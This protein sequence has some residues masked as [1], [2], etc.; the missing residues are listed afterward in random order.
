MDHEQVNP[1]ERDHSLRVVLPG[2]VEK[3]ATVHGS[4]AVMDLLVTLCASYHLNPSDYTVEVLSANRDNVSFKPN[5]PI[6][7]LEA[8]KIVLRSRGAVEEKIRRPYMPEATVRLLINYNKSHKTVVR[9]NPRLPLATLLPAVCDKCEFNVGTTVLLRD[10]RSGETL[11]LSRTLNE[12]GLREVF[13]RDTAGKEPADH[14][15]GAA[16]AEVASPPPLQELPKKEQKEQKEQKEN[17]GFLSLFRR[18]KKK[19][20][21]EGEVSVPPAPG[22]GERA[23]VGLESDGVSSS[24]ALPADGPKKRRAP[25]PPPGASLSLTN[26]LSSCSLGGAQTSAESTL[27]STK[28][29]APPPPPCANPLQELQ[30]DAGDRGGVE[31]LNAAEELGRSDE[32][33]SVKLSLSSSPRLSRPPPSSRPSLASHL[34]RVA[35]PYLPSV[36]GRDL[37]DYRDALAKVLTS[38]VSKATLVQRLKGSASFPRFHHSSAS[39]SPA[40]RPDDG[41][42]LAELESVLRSNLLRESE[43]EGPASRRGTTTFTV[44]PQKKPERLQISIEEREAPREE[45]Q[46]EEEPP[47]PVRSDSPSPEPPTQQIQAPDDDDDLRDLDSQNGPQSEVEDA[48]GERS[49]E[50]EEEEEPE[51]EA[52]SRV[53]RSPSDDVDPCGPCAEE[54]EETSEEAREE[55]RQ[56][57]VG[58]PPPPPPVFFNEDAEGPPSRFSQAVAMA[59]QKSRLQSLV[60]RLGPQRSGGPD[61]P[62]P[63]R[64]T[65]QY[66]EFSATAVV[67]ESNL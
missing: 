39:F 48:A 5:S 46:E 37:S 27:R 63:P 11:D 7:S 49:E 24:N 54:E 17:T 42:L 20:E 21:A 33:A 57:E 58:F 1:L 6:G 13:A 45:A 62:S 43:W 12:H 9:V 41:V 26:N 67:L 29:R 32:S 36:R 35:D 31:S 38:S 53:A 52:T 60:K 22:L 30:V 28:R 25:P 4:K 15:P 65:Y 44:V 61:F 8:E 19:H 47:S 40:T 18:R 64:S 2:G 23:G 3:N 55:E 14:R 56:E 50:E 34:H 16:E 66:G 59:V 51:P 10:G